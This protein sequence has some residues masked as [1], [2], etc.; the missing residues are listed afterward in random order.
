MNDSSA[1]G[2]Q[3][4][5][6]TATLGE[7]RLSDV[8]GD[9]GT[10]D[11]PPTTV[12]EEGTEFNGSFASTCPIEVR[13]RVQGDLAAPSLSVAASGAVHGKVQV[14]ELRSEGEISGEFDADA[15][16]LSGVVKDN[17]VL[18]ASS[19]EMTLAPKDHRMQ[20]IFGECQPAQ[21]GG[22]ARRVS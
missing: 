13:G 6:R 3:A 19:L 12:V 1:K 5:P 15:A 14:S 10:H 8:P 16:H 22:K 11:A 4:S 18:R 17:T 20:L 21:A 7:P 9:W 2:H